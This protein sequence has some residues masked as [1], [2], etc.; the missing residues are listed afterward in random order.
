LQPASL[1]EPTCGVGNFVLAAMDRFENI[2]QVV[3]ADINA[4][5]VAR[6]AHLLGE[7]HD[8]AGA[9]L[10]QADFFATDWR[11]IISQLPEPILILGN[12]PWATSAQLGA[13]GSKN[14]PVKANFHKHRGLDAITGKANFDISEWMLIR[15]LE[16]MIGRHGT[17]AMLCKSSTARK[18]LSYAWKNGMALERSRLYG[19]DAGLH[20]DAAVDAVLLVANFGHGAHVREAE[21]FGHLRET[22]AQNTIGLEDGMLLADVAAYHQWKHL[23]GDEWFKWRS[24][25]KHDCAKVMELSREGGLYRNGLGE[26][27][28]LEDAYVYPMLKS[29]SVANGGETANNRLML[30]TQTTVR[31]HPDRIREKGPKTWAYLQSHADH[32]NKRASSIYRN[33]PA[34]SI[35]GVGSYSFAPWK[36]AISGFYTRLRFLVVNPLQG[37]PV[38]LDDTSYFLP[39]QTNDEATYL[40]SLLNSPAAQS[41]YRSFIFWDSKRPV[42]AELLRRLDLR[43]LAKELGS[44]EAF[45]SFFPKPSGDPVLAASS[46]PYEAQLGFWS[47]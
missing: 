41:F 17:L 14:L 39:C 34:F 11:Q 3:G 40:A 38:V 28:E 8:M 2:Q 45:D 27:V 25:I 29:S 20:F 6:A 19:I 37:K 47:H 18:V 35:F 33:R 7:R 21:V 16:G 1:L 26:L 36:V 44:E 5:Y 30:V 22:S 31:E 23:C 46:E 10:I 4:E 24:G 12:P 43:R 32:F 42:T 13:L 15:L 9:R